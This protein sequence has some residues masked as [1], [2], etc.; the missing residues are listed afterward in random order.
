MLQKVHQLLVIA[1]ATS[2]L[3][4]P[5]AWLKEQWYVKT[6]PSKKNFDKEFFALENT[7]KDDLI[8]CYVLY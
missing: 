5:L 6:F 4:V 8:F 7:D 2:S 3:Q 1:D